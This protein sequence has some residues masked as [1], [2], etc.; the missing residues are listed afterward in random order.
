MNT[1][2]AISDSLISSLCREIDFIRYRYKRINESLSLCK[3]NLVKERLIEEITKLNE[4]RIELIGISNE[5][6]N[7]LTPSTAKLFLYELCKRP[8]DF[9]I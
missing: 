3:N 2:V 9:Y 5:M 1:E 4:R 7:S 6:Q 8:L